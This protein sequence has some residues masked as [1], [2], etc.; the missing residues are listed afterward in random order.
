MIVDPENEP[1]L[2]GIPDTELLDILSVRCNTTEPQKQ[3]WEL[4]EQQTEVYTKIQIL[5]Q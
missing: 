5:I 2:L 1:I 3:I 4:N